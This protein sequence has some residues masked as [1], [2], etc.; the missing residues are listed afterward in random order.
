MIAKKR[1][2][3][4]ADPF[5]VYQFNDYRTTVILT[6]LMPLEVVTF[7]KY[8]PEFSKEVLTFT[9]LEFSVFLL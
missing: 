8:T 3:Q 7:T 4:L 2:D 5:I 9:N 6:V 1:V